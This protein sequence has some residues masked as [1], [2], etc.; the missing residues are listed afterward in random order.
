[1]S[2]TPGPWHKGRGVIVYAHDKNVGPEDFP[3]AECFG[4]QGIP[5]ARLIAAA[6]ELLEALRRAL[7]Y[8][9]KAPLEG[10]LDRYEEARVIIAKATGE[11]PS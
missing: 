10:V 9:D 8:L 7:P 2:Y 6:P 1:M 5:N 3:V 11:S 4:P